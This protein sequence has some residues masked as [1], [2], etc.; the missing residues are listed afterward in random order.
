MRTV[1][2]SFTEVNQSKL[3]IAAGLNHDIVQLQIAMNNVALL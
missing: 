3:K 1:N 2:E